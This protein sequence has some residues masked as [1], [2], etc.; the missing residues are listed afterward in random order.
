MG[1]MAFVIGPL[2]GR[3]FAL[4]PSNCERFLRD[5]RHTLALCGSGPIAHEWVRGVE[6]STGWGDLSCLTLLSLNRHFSVPTQTSLRTERAWCP[7]C[8]DLWRDGG[9]VLYTPLLWMMRA[10]RL[11][12]THGTAMMTV[13]PNVWCRQKRPGLS[14]IRSK[15]TARTADAGSARA[16]SRTCQRHLICHP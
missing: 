7:D 5:Q 3:R 2:V 8:L 10:V 6:E 14:R 11:C 16:V 4:D 12:P 13:C 1:L 9:S 15:G